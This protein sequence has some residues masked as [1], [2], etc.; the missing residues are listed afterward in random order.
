LLENCCSR[1][2]LQGENE[3]EDDQRKDRKTSSNISLMEL[4]L[5][6]IPNHDEEN[7]NI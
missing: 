5:S 3:S 2:L 1:H 7:E 6:S 4:E